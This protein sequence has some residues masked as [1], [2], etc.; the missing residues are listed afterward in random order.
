MAYT[1]WNMKSKLQS[2]SIDRNDNSISLSPIDK[3]KRSLDNMIKVAEPSSI[4]INPLKSAKVI[5]KFRIKTFFSINTNRSEEE[6]NKMIEET[7]NF[8]YSYSTLSTISRS[9]YRKIA[10][11]Y[12]ST[13][14]VKTDFNFITQPTRFDEVITDISIEDLKR[15]NVISSGCLETSTLIDRQKVL[16]QERLSLT[17]VDIHEKIETVR[18]LKS[19]ISDLKML[20]ARMAEILG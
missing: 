3:V 9:T 7:T 14:K 17:N 6:I 8:M 18:D 15:Q 13:Y 20:I 11:K 1:S 4:I 16:L 12:I 10:I 2:I 19:R 5:S